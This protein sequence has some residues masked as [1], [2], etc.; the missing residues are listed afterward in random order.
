MQP[1]L[2]EV[3]VI[4]SGNI[5][6][7]R[8]DY[9]VWSR[10]AVIDIWDTYSSR[11]HVGVSSEGKVYM[12][13]E[14]RN[15]RGYGP[16][17]GATF[18]H[19]NKEIEEAQKKF[20]GKEDECRNLPPRRLVYIGREPGTINQNNPASPPIYIISSNQKPTGW[21]GTWYTAQSKDDI[22]NRLVNILGGI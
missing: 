14:K 2:P 12:M 11:M 1:L 16:S 22:K 10:D 5:S 6:S 17:E 15:L 21:P 13:T 7:N 4:I 3:V 19:V 8:G 18:H 9:Y 20:T